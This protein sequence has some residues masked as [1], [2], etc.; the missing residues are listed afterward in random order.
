MVKLEKIH[1]VFA[2]SLAILLLDSL[3]ILNFIKRPVDKII[4]PVKKEIFIFRG[5]LN[6]FTNTLWSYKQIAQVYQDRSD[7]V[8]TAEEMKLELKQLTQE[9][10]KLR[11]QLEAPFPP[12][13]KF[14]PA[15]VIGVSRYM[16]IDGGSDQ[17]IKV[18]QIVADGKTLVGK[19][20]QSAPRRS[21]IMLVADPDF[22]VPAVT[23]RDT[24]GEVT[25]QSGQVITLS[26]V[27][28][29]DPLFLD[30]QVMTAG[31]EITPPNLLVG[32]VTYITAE[33]A[34]TYKQ[35]KITPLINFDREKFVF[36]I[37][38]L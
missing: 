13:Y 18:G 7:L 20:V 37:T 2:S 12:S 19:I 35:A 31:D 24:R 15:Q 32:K 36:V 4:I 25:G 16:E 21:K 28:Q 8:K 14:V 26:K 3:G 29:K 17:G 22:R 9:N 33:E 11:T 6:D 30:D 34:A 38:S 10:A 1:W 23:S 27:L 5:V